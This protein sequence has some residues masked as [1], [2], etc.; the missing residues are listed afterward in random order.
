MSRRLLVFVLLL[1]ACGSSMPDGVLPPAKMQSA[2]WDMLRAD[3]MADYYIQH[4]S[5]KGLIGKRGQ[6]YGEVFRVQGITEDVFKRSLRYYETHPDKFKIILDSLQNMG[7]RLQRSDTSHRTIVPAQP[8]DPSR[9]AQPPIVVDSARIKKR[10]MHK[11]LH[12]M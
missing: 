10:R 9:A 4:D 8:L 2:M 3:E 6:F 7:E 1:T 12:S 11:S 5:T